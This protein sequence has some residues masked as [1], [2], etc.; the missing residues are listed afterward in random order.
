MLQHVRSHTPSQL[1]DWLCH[2][3]DAGC[4]LRLCSLIAV[5]RWSGWTLSPVSAYLWCYIYR[6]PS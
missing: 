3:F 5:V 2:H 6:I 4:G 1:Q